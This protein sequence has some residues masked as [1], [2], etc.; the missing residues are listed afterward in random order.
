MKY[1]TSL[2]YQS[3]KVVIVGDGGIGKTCMLT[4]L[5][6][7]DVNQEYKP[8]VFENFE[9]ITC[10]NGIG[11]KISLWDTAGQEGYEN[12]RTFS[13]HGTDIFVICHSVDDPSS[14]MNINNKWIPEVTRT[15][16]SAPII[17]VGLKSD[18]RFQMNL[19]REVNG[20]KI[21]N[22]LP[23]SFDEAEMEAEKFGALK[24]FECSSY[25]KEG[26]NAVFDFAFEES[27]KRAP[28][29]LLRR[30]KAKKCIIC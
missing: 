20:S 12:I 10:L 29:R 24:Y 25:T 13:Y 23:L 15:C 17:V 21:V 3:I 8:T 11:I 27:L 30:K 6:G 19:N 2:M 5:T 9:T 1:E 14:F 18:L 4:A 26:L 16:P 22:N 7:G 28:P